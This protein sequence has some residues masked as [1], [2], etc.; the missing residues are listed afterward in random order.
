MALAV[1]PTTSFEDYKQHLGEFIHHTDIPLTTALSAYDATTKA[2]LFILLKQVLSPDLLQPILEQY[3]PIVKK[4]TSSNRGLAA[5]TIHRTKHGT[6]EKSNTVH[7]TVAGYIDSPN[8]KYPCRLTKFSKDHFT[9]YQSGLPLLE[10]I[11]SHFQATLPQ[12]YAA[13]QAAAEK[14]PFRIPNTAF[15]TVTMN[16]NFQTAIHLDKGDYPQGFGILVVCSKDISG[17][18]LLFPRYRLRIPLQTGDL[19][20]MNVHEYH[21][22]LPI[23][24]THPAGYRLSLVCYLREKL[25][26]CKQNQFLRDLGLPENKRWDTSLI[27]DKILQQL[28]FSPANKE[29]TLEGWWS[30]E[31]EHYHFYYRKKQYILKDKRTNKK[32]ICLYNIM[33][34]LESTTHPPPV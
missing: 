24:A 21:C 19:L 3:L 1:T 29:I 22:N 34:Y 10:K 16:Y 32:T 18:E 2:P 5:G 14:T 26:D 7:S 33:A 25:L 6:Y 27:I 23:V 17:G 31:N 28:H 20:F 15:T 11:S 12:Q 30:Y 9:A 8:H 13:Q 4:M